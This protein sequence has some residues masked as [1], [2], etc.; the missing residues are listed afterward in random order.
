MVVNHRRQWNHCYKCF[1]PDYVSSSVFSA[2]V[3]GYYFSPKKSSG[4]GKNILL[5]VKICLLL[6]FFC[7]VFQYDRMSW[8][9]SSY[10]LEIWVKDAFVTNNCIMDKPSKGST[11]YKHW[12]LEKRTFKL[13]L[14]VAFTFTQPMFDIKMM[15]HCLLN[16]LESINANAK[17]MNGQLDWPSAPPTP[18]PSCSTISGHLHF[19]EA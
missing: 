14:M 4:E 16:H 6:I 11:S 19:K 2:L 5:W 15:P 9:C 18:K 13:V 12:Y 3:N 7:T 17:I 1:R 10:H 8:G